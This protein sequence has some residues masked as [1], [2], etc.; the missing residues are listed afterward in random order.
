MKS[1]FSLFLLWAGVY[2]SL[3]QASYP[4]L[5]PTLKYSVKGM[6][7]AS[8][9]VLAADG[10]NVY[11]LADKAYVYKADMQGKKIQKIDVKGYDI[12]G[13]TLVGDKLY[14]SD[15][16][17]RQVLCYNLSTQTLEKTHQLHYG[18][19][20]NLGFE[21]IVH[22]PLSNTFLLASEKSPC[23]FHEYSETFQ[24]LNQ[25]Q[26]KGIREVSALC[27][28]QNNLYVLSDE[29]ATVYKVDLQKHTIINAWQVP[30]INPEGLCFNKQGEMMIISDDMGKLFVFSNPEQ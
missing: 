4:M 24:L 23:V 3:A 25:F 30:I 18:G 10:Q 11:I 9:I 15:E 5:R 27:W 1:I 28:Y 22:L 6:S 21:S 26:I 12:E 16:N 8:E 2:S 29:E 14:I 13:A 17:L 20:A 7:E 19:G